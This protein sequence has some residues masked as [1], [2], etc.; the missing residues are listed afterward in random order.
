MLH[1]GLP[2]S[3][4]VCVCVRVRECVLVCV[5]LFMHVCVQILLHI[6]PVM[7]LDCPL[8]SIYTL[9]RCSLHLSPLSLLLSVSYSKY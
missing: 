9:L 3:L 4:A 8:S 5:C 1:D 7:L 2:Y 6:I